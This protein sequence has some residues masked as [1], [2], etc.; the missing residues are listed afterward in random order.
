MQRPVLPVG[1]QHPEDVDV[2]LA[3]A[4]QA[5]GALLTRW[6]TG[7][8]TTMSDEDIAE[9]MMSVW[10]DAA[11]R[12]VR[13]LLDAVDDDDLIDLLTI[14]YDGW[15]ISKYRQF[16]GEPGDGPV[17]AVAIAEWTGWAYSG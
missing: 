1:A 6:R 3:V 4:E 5:A 15:T 8:L 13:E 7:L 2:E 9:A 10:D 17:M 12:P 11:D 14:G 16:G